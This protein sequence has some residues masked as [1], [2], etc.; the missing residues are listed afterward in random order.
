MGEV[1]M[2]DADANA[3]AFADTKKEKRKDVAEAAKADEG[4]LA[5]DVE[6]AE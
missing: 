1:E 6:V 5:M 3:A 4:L 2:K